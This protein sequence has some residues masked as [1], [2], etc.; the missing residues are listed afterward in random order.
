[1]RAITQNVNGNHV[2]TADM[3]SFHIVV[4]S[5]SNGEYSGYHHSAEDADEK[6]CHAFFSFFALVAFLRSTSTLSASQMDP[7]S[8]MM[9]STQTL[10]V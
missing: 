9:F 6:Q 3:M 1:M 2:H 5:F 7:I 8:V 10:Q 4:I